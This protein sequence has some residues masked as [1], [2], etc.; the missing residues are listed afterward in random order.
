MEFRDGA[1]VFTANEEKIGEIAGVVLDPSDREVTHLIIERGFLLNRDKLVD[2]DAVTSTSPDRVM[3][4]DDVDPD[5][6]IPYEDDQFISIAQTPQDDMSTRR[7]LAPEM[8][9]TVVWYAPF[10]PAA[11]Y[12]AF[13]RT[14]LHVT[15]RMTSPSSTIEMGDKVISADGE[16]LGKVDDIITSDDEVTG[17][18]IEK[19]MFFTEERAIPAAWVASI[20]DG[21]VR[22]SVDAAMAESTPAHST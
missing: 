15:Q 5:E 13:L 3:L 17:F 16:K 7:T 19:G 1:P 22:L 2:V 11:A 14:E 10:E 9:R 8:R 6:L 12:P 21:E 4:S 20:E 18:M